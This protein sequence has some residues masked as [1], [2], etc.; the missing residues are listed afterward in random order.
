[1]SSRPVARTAF[2]IRWLRPPL[3]DWTDGCSQSASFQDVPNLISGHL[4]RLPCLW[5]I[6]DVDGAV[7][8]Q[9]VGGC[10]SGTPPRSIAVQHENDTLEVL[11]E[12]VLLGRVQ[13]R[14]HQCDHRMHAGLMQLQTVEEAF[15]NHD[16]QPLVT[17]RC[18][19]KS[20]SE[21]VGEQVV[22]GEAVRPHS[23][24]YAERFERHLGFGVK[25]PI[26]TGELGTVRPEC[27]L[28]LFAKLRYI[29]QKID[30]GLLRQVIS[31]ARFQQRCVPKPKHA[32]NRVRGAAFRKPSRVGGG[33]NGLDCKTADDDVIGVK[34][35]SI[36]IKGN[37]DPR[38]LPPYGGDDLTAN[39]VDRRGPE[40]LVLIGQNIDFA[41]AENTR[42]FPH[43]GFPYA[44]QFLN[45]A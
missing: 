45:R 28:L 36:G 23:P 15:Y 1:V 7:R 6:D 22:S 21:L 20:N 19:L 8:A 14:S 41:N 5:Q 42:R 29:D 24:T 39:I 27:G 18:R 26:E 44:R 17:A 32:F 10:G 37:D 3:L 4:V 33:G 9:P 31:P 11:Q 40:L 2:A 13:R 12:G 30:P 25:Q 34:I 38:A 35:A 43:F 16:D